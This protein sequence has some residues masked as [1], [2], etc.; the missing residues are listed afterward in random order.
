MHPRIRL[1]VMAVAAMGAA[2]IPS[3]SPAADPIE[4]FTAFAVDTSGVTGRGARAGTVDIA[5][6]RWTTP[7]ERARLRAALQEDGNSGLLSALRKV[8]P[9]TGYVRS[10]TGLGYPLR[11]AVQID[12]P[13]GGRRILIATDR[14]ISFLELRQ[15]SSVTDEYPFM[16]IDMR[17]DASGEGEGKLIPLARIQ[18]NAD[19]VLDIDNYAAQPVRLTK[20][21][22]VS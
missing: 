1:V 18:R 5:I 19:H 3:L 16:V 14:P 11:F 4:R 22:K 2:A 17:L 12:Q 10:G 6:E 20:V 15:G 21:K 9:P 7:E 13:G 8:E